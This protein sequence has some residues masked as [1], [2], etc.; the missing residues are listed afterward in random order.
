[1]ARDQELMANLAPHI[2]RYGER[3]RSLAERGIVDGELETYRWMVEELRVSL[4]AQDLGTS[5]PVS[6]KRLDGQWE[7]VRV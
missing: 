7:R 6:G 1:V 4:F 2:K 3:A 5:M